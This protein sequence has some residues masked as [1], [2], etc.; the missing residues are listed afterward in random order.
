MTSPQDFWNWFQKNNSKYYFLNQITDES[1]KEKLLDEF[2]DK[3]HQFSEG[4]FF[5]IGGFPDEPQDLII[6]AEGNTDYFNQVEDLVAS[7]PAM[8]DWTIIAF[9]PPK[10]FG[11]ITESGD[12][13]LDPSTIWFVLLETEETQEPG[14]RLFI[15]DYDA[16]KEQDYRYAASIALDNILGEK[17]NA[18]RIKF[19]EIEETPHEPEELGLV[20]LSELLEYLTTN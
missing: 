17:L 13:S 11:Y 6:T 3:L 8:A 1:E 2:I 16:A 5:E 19:L 20:K 10:E 15:E 9:K 18:D 14:I 12:I 4:L 7:A